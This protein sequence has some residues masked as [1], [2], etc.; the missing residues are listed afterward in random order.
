M[1]RRNFLSFLGIGA[2]GAATC[3]EPPPPMLDPE[4]AIAL[5]EDMKGV[6]R[7][8]WQAPKVLTNVS[9]PGHTHGYWAVGEETSTAYSYTGEMRASKVW[10]NW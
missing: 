5:P 1:N 9:D 3:I 8:M 6:H 10:V 4:K 7:P 2:I